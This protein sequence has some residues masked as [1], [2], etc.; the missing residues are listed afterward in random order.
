MA[1][2]IGGIIQVQ[3]D[4]TILRAKGDF[5]YMLGGVKR[6][7]V[8]GTDGEIHGYKETTIV[9]SIEG[10]ITDDGTVDIKALQGLTDGTI[11]LRLA[12]GKLISQSHSWYAAEG[13]ATTA[14]GEVEV[15]WEG[16]TSE[17]IQP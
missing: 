9:P 17:E 15:R 6:E 11:T 14:E 16:K 2:R 8:V 12:N 4:G 5:T 13:K 7:A 3:V 1:Q 10:A